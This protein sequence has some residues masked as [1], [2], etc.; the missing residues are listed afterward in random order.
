MSKRFSV[1]LPDGL[2]D[3]VEGLSRYSKQTDEVPAL[4]QAR[5]IRLLLTDSAAR[6]CEG[7]EFDVH[8]RDLSEDVDEGVLRDLVPDHVRAKFL[9]E[10]VKSENWLADM[11]GGF[12]G[13]VRDALARR[14]KNG[15][16]P[17][18]AAEVAEGYVKE[19]R[20][21]WIMIEDDEETFEEK[22]NYV[23]DRLED[24]RERYDVSDY[25]LEDEWLSGFE[26][27]ER[28]E[29]V[30]E[31]RSERE[32]FIRRLWNEGKTRRQISREFS[33]EF[34]V[35][36][37]QAEDAVKAVLDDV[38]ETGDEVPPALEVADD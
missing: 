6:L 28:G 9:R 7:G 36:T 4:P 3:L 27:V 32:Q 15:Y 20:I 17:E 25:D 13:R 21:Y 35:A 34:A 10:E 16:D 26:G 12:E 24:Y 29:E 23:H 1:T 30:R 14:F 38:N 5:V 8:G 31:E 2:A 37:N 19:A 18:A 11:K 22:R 33:R